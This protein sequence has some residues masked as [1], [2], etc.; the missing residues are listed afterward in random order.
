MRRSRGAA[1]LKTGFTLI[2]LLV[3][4]AIIGV[5]VALI[6]PAV[7]S[8]REAANRAKCQNNLKQLGLAGQEYHDTFLSLP[9]GW[10]CNEA[11]W[12]ASSGC[13]AGDCN[14]L[15]WS[16]QAY[17][18]NGLTS[19]LLLKLE[20]T[21]LWNEINFNLAPT[22][23]DNTTAT[24]RTIEAFVC[25][26]NRKATAVA[27]GTS[28]ASKLGPSD[29]RGNSAADG[30][31]AC[32]DAATLPTNPLDLSTSP[33]TQFDN[34]VAYKNSSVSMAD[35]TDG[36]TSTMFIGEV[37]YPKNY[38]SDGPSSCV[39]TLLGR[40]INKPI[41]VGTTNY[42]SYWASKHPGLVNF[43]RCDGSVGTVTSQINKLVLLK[44]MTRAGGES[45]SS[46]EIK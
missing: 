30:N 14:C 35:I 11:Q 40:T 25:P 43:A 42:W 3:V 27:S 24:R 20:Q 8:A 13:S 36:T 16:S 41:T 46:D 33:C 6:M 1:R 34:G 29:Y 38:W 22:A 39:R 28:T 7:Q 17:M 12:D 32:N 5:L 37:I 45:I 31:I 15:P 9:S 19:G 44:L 23:I 26:S 18:W 10:F 2:E 21:N 4:I